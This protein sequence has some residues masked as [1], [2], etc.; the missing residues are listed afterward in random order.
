MTFVLLNNSL[1]FGMCMWN[2][3]RVI[4]SLLML[5][6]SYINSFSCTVSFVLFFVE[7]RLSFYQL[8]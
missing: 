5:D 1:E 4:N 3:W 6:T 8:L 2:T 7:T